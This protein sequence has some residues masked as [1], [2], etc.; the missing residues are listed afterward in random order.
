ML[1]YD[2]SPEGSFLWACL[3]PTAIEDDSWSSQRSSIMRTS[4]KRN[5]SK[6]FTFGIFRL[7]L[8]LFGLCL[9]AMLAWADF[10]EGLKA[11]RSGDY[12]FAAK[13]WA[14]LAEKGDAQA[15]GQLARLYYGGMG[16]AKDPNRAAALARQAAEQGDA[17][18]QNLLGV[19][20]YRGE[21]G[22][23]KNREQSVVWFRKAAE[24]GHAKAQTNLGENYW[25]GEG[26]KRDERLAGDW[27][28]KAADQG[29]D[30]GQFMLGRYY[31]NL[32]IRDFV[33]GVYWYRKAA[34]QGHPIALQYLAQNYEF[35]VT[36]QRWQ[37]AYENEEAD[38]LND[39]ASIS[40]AS[41]RDLVVA[42]ALYKL[43]IQAGN[44]DS[45]SDLSLLSSQLSAGQREEGDALAA[46][47]KV[48]LPLPEKSRTGAA[49]R[50][51][52]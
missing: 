5:K 21:G 37:E 27:F 50:I 47:W 44:K 20:Y 9:T 35:S 28:R 22:L 26:I 18:G 2:R 41:P 42:Y 34:E 16:V 29:Y 1:P 14:L 17:E 49:P 15:Q 45:S 32:G 48:G 24:Q 51:V 33:N 36:K 52:P 38:E 6:R 39:W 40:N 10:D 12:V 7:S 43:S 11:Y 31:V 13:E 25:K 4:T 23:E 8:G 46:E 19:L 3:M 30:E